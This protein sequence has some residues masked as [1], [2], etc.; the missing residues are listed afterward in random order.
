MKNVFIDHEK[1][2]EAIAL[3][4]KEGIPTALYMFVSNCEKY[5]RR[6]AETYK[7]AIGVNYKVLHDIYM[8]IPGSIW[9]GMQKDFLNYSKAKIAKDEADKKRAEA[10]AERLKKES[11]KKVEQ[12]MKARKAAAVEKEKAEKKL[13]PV[14]KVKEKE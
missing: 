11:E 13:V 4:N 1:A 6:R 12:E 5:R 9:T 8:S 10:D 3:E 14:E 2:I 7:G